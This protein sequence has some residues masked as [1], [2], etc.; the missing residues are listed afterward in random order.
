MITNKGSLKKGQTQAKNIEL[1]ILRKEKVLNQDVGWQLLKKHDVMYQLQFQNLWLNLDFKKYSDSRYTR[2]VRRLKKIGLENVSEVILNKIPS[3][4]CRLVN[5]ILGLLPKKKIQKL[6]FDNTS[7]VASK[8]WGFYL[9][10]LARMGGY[11]TKSL[12]IVGVKFCNSQFQ[13]L[14][15]SSS[16]TREVCFR[17]WTIETKSLCLK[18]SPKYKTETLSFI[19]W[20]I[21]KFSN[22][23]DHPEK[24]NSI[25][26]AISESRMVKSLKKIELLDNEIS[27]AQ[28]Q[29]CQLGERGMGRCNLPGVQFELMD[30]TLDSYM[31]F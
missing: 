26:F 8:P 17:E 29:S 4:R 13:N 12:T 9:R 19:E 16:S 5:D 7:D 22:W 24:L 27:H 18:E 6:S 21:E 3:R 31:D 15:I 11:T 30:E 2:E 1:S 10:H 14:L 23:R 28:L 20:G 25:L